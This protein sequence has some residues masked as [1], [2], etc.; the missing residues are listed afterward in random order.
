[1]GSVQVLKALKTLQQS[2]G[3][4]ALRRSILDLSRDSGPVKSYTV[5]FD[6]NKRTALCYLEMRYPLLDAE[7][8]EL[9][10]VGF[11][12]GLVLEFPVGSEFRGTDALCY[13]ARRAPRLTPPWLP[14]RSPPSPISR[15]PT[16]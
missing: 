7:V 3:F 11:G 1:M 6:S 10:A 15:S 5:S 16:R 12:S 8:R 2:P 4:D 13:E 14:R 9:G